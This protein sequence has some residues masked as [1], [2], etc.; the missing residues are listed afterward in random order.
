MEE[1]RPQLS[2]EYNDRSI[3]CS[4]EPRSSI[5]QPTCQP[6]TPTF[7]AA[8]LTGGKTT[9]GQAQGFH[10]GVMPLHGSLAPSACKLML[11]SWVRTLIPSEA[12]PAAKASPDPSGAVAY[13]NNSHTEMKSEWPS[14]GTG[15]RA[16]VPSCCN[17]CSVKWPVLSTQECSILH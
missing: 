3:W 6:M 13:H 16:V 11:G 4:I 8:H 7:I 1:N 17:P 10:M 2:F 14:T 5:R 15:P 9:G 12:L